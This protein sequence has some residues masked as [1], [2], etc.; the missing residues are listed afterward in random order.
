MNLIFWLIIMAIGGLV[1]WFLIDWHDHFP[2][3]E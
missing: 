3:G 1:I 2:D